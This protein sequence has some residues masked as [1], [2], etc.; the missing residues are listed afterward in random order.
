MFTFIR[1]YFYVVI[2]KETLETIYYKVVPAKSSY[3][4]NFT[5]HDQI[6]RVCAF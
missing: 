1:C 4:E 6:T 3:S 2:C 5:L